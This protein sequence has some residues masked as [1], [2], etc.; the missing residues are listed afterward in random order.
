MGKLVKNAADLAKIQ[1]ARE[2]ELQAK[3]QASI[4]VKWG[5]R[6]DEAKARLCHTCWRGLEC[7]LLPICQDGSDCPYHRGPNESTD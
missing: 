5:N 3:V 4:C 6:V 1:L 2:A 7:T